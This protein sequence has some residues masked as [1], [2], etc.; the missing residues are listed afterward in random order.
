MEVRVVTPWCRAC[1]TEV[2]YG[3]EA[4]QIEA[5]TPM[6]T[7]HWAAGNVYHKACAE[8]LVKA[9]TEAVAEQHTDAHCTVTGFCDPCTRR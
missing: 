3:Q 7:P 1:D 6:E 2:R 9:E 8:V 4:A 5:L